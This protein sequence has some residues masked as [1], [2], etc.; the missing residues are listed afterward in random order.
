MKS[1]AN[2]FFGMIIMAVLYSFTMHSSHKDKDLI[3]NNMHFQKIKYYIDNSSGD[4][5]DRLSHR[6]IQEWKT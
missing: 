2:L 1:K 4:I 6:A 3:I 5:R